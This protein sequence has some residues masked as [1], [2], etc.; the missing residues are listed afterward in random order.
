MAKDEKYPRRG[1]MVIATVTKVNPFSATVRLDEYNNIEGMIHVSEVARRWVKDIKKVVKVGQKIVPA[2]MRVDYEKGH[3]NLSLKRINKYDADE[4]LKEYKREQ[5]ADRMLRV[6]AKRSKIDIN[7]AYEKVGYKL[8]EEFGELFKAFQEAALEGE[9]VLVEKGIDKKDAEVLTKV[10]KDQLEAKEQK[11][12]KTVMI[13]S[14][15]PDG[16]NMIKK[17][18]QEVEKKFDVEIRYV[19]APEYSITLKTKSAK[20]GDR[21]L[22]ESVKLIEEKICIGGG[23]CEIKGE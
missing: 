10:A 7:K 3:V 17:A 21:I 6:F 12:K 16:V 13:K 18:L 4:K 11:M 15:A 20:E 22:S 19:S 5:K 2:V 23:E 1:E 9:N 8:R 14:Y